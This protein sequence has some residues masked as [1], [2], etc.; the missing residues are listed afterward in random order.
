MPNSWTTLDLARPTYHLRCLARGLAP[1]DDPR[2]A[3]ALRVPLGTPVPVLTLPEAAN[4][5]GLAGAT[6]VHTQERREAGKGLAAGAPGSCTLASLLATADAYGLE[7]E[8]R[9]R[10]R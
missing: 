5:L 8:V 7:V 4:L 2:R 1:V 9:V 3:A 10:R 6:S